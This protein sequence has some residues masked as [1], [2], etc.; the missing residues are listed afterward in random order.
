MKVISHWIK[1]FEVF[2]LKNWN[3]EKC[4]HFGVKLCLILVSSENL[5]YILKISIMNH[6]VAH[7]QNSTDD[8]KLVCLKYYQWAMQNDIKR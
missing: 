4:K 5:K 3:I 7:Y 2:C 6:T 1:H 8:K